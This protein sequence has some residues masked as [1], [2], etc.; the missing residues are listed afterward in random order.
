[1]WTAPSLQGVLQRFD[2]IAC[3]RMSGL[4]AR[5]HMNAGQDGFRDES[6]KQMSDL[7]EGHRRMR[8]FSHRGL[9]DRTI[10]SSCKFWHRLSTVAVEWACGKLWGRPHDGLCRSQ[11]HVL[12]PCESPKQ[13]DSIWFCSHTVQAPANPNLYAATAWPR[14][15]EW[16][17]GL[18]GRTESFRSAASA[19]LPGSGRSR[20]PVAGAC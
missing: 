5:S 20:Y 7:I 11:F 9:I 3:A 2:Q 8:Y 18:Y 15:P 14:T 10:Y 12:I 1:M 4:F 19:F 17:A 6:S 16:S 13:T